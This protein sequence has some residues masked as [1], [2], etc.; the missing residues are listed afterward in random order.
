MA[1]T[2][3]T[4]VSRIIVHV[5]PHL[6]ELVALYLVIRY[7]DEHFEGLE[8][9]E[10]NFT[11]DG[12]ATVDGRSAEEWLK[13]G[14]LHIGT[15]GG[16]F[17]EHPRGG[18]GEITS[19]AAALVAEFLGVQKKPELMALL[20]YVTMTD[21]GGERAPSANEA[22]FGLKTLVDTLHR[23]GTAT[24]EVMRITFA[25]VDAVVARQQALFAAA[26]DDVRA[27]EVYPFQHRR[28]P[29]T[30]AVLKSGNRFAAEA[31][32]MLGHSAVVQQQPDGH[33]QI[34]VSKAAKLTLWDLAAVLRLE[35]ADR[36]GLDLAEKYRIIDLKSADSVEE[37]PEWYYLKAGQM[38]LNGS[39]SAPDVPV[40]QIPL[41]RIVELTV[42]TLN[43][44][45]WPQKLAARCRAGYCSDEAGESEC[46]MRWMQLSRCHQIRESMKGM[47]R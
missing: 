35:E 8:S 2:I 13:E 19:C 29:H 10:V 20:R 5:K 36:K 34:F 30:L 31:A 21:T 41:E 39:D 25:L 45:F 9:A 40:S 16:R 3:R 43:E 32:R 11:G 22:L 1:A 6:D 27:A 28:Q 4:F 44:D 7:G 12:G 47:Q 18:S 38:L 37:V 24:E 17:D 15:G 33:V 26:E 23:T 14:V 42:R 46:P